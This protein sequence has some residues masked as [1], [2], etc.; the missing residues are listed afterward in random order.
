MATKIWSDTSV[1]AI[2]WHSIVIASRFDIVRKS[3]LLAQSSCSGSLVL[4]SS[5]FERD[6]LD[7]GCW[8]VLSIFQQ[9]KMKA[10]TI[11]NE[12]SCGFQQGGFVS[13]DQR[14][15]TVAT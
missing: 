12:A 6:L 11:R 15:D 7:R 1:A 3:A 5:F 2:G 14:N 8:V 4:H 13:G 9:N 10:I